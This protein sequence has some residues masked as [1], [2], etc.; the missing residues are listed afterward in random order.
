MPG[1]AIIRAAI[2]TAGAVVGGCVVTAV[3]NN[4]N[5]P[6]T[7]KSDPPQPVTGLDATGK[8]EI[9]TEVTETSG[10]LPILKYGNPGVSRPS[11]F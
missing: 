10:L 4:R 9:S 6:V 5:R 8:T 7:P 1:A 11:N 2:F 3:A